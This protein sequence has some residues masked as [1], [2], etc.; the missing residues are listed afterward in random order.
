MGVFS[1]NTG[2]ERILS[3]I[4]MYENKRR[5]CIPFSWRY[6]RLDVNSWCFLENEPGLKDNEAMRGSERK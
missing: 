1:D 5:T 2:M 6:K 4:F 3:A